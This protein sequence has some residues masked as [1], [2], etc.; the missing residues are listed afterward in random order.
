MPPEKD[1]I[2]TIKK[3]PKESS[4]AMKESKEKDAAKDKE[5]AHQIDDNIVNFFLSLCLS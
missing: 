2:S 1:V 4:V 5:V 3:E